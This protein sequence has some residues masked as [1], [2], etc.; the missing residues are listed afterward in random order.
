VEFDVAA[1]SAQNSATARG[2]S[3]NTAPG[4]CTDAGTVCS[5]LPNPNGVATCSASPTNSITIGKACGVPQDFIATGNPASA[6]PGTQLTNQS[7]LAAVVVNFSGTIDNTGQ[8]ALTGVTVTD[9]PST[10][11]TVNWPG[12]PGT[13]QPGTTVTYTGSYSPSGSAILGDGTTT[14]RY[15]FKD[16]IK[17]TGATATLGSSPGHEATCMG[18]FNTDAQACSDATCGICPGGANC[19]GN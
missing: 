13:I 7:G 17:V 5:P 18:T 3:A 4:S 16:L 10:T 11:V 15:Q 6:I 8:T 19:S 12:T 14:G 2:D 1:T 9:N